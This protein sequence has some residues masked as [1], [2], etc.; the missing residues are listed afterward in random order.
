[1]NITLDDIRSKAPKVATHYMH[2]GMVLGTG[3]NVVLY[4]KLFNGFYYCW[5]CNEWE[6]SEYQSDHRNFISNIKPL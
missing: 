6:L 5:D 3:D 2:V 4:Y 1:M